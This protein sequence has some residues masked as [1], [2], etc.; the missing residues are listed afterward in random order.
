M[1]QIAGL[2]NDGRDELSFGKPGATAMTEYVIEKRV[3]SDQN[4]SKVA[5]KRRETAL[6]VTPGPDEPAT[7]PTLIVKDAEFP[8]LLIY[9]TGDSS[10]DE[11]RIADNYAAV[12][13]KK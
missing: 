4:S 1:N 3:G 9:S 12:A 10:L 11:I 8:K 5:G 2:A 7:G 13:P 6:L